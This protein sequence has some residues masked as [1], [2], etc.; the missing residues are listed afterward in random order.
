MA[1]APAHRARLGLP[2]TAASGEAARAF[3]APVW[4]Y[5]GFSREPG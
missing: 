5:V 4:A 3:D 2:L 1:A